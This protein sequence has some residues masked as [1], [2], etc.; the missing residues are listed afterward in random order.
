VYIHLSE[1][2]LE[3]AVLR[4]HGL[5]PEEKE[6]KLTL[7][8]C[9]RCGEG[10]TIGVKGC[11]KCGFIIDEQLARKTVQEEQD[12]FGSLSKRIERQEEVQGKILEVLGSIA[13]DVEGMKVAED[14][15]ITA[16]T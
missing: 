9:P 13:K 3:N 7:K 16:S 5:Q 12:V 11:V 8:K 4:E 1:S 15:I 2:D 14:D 10:N 6:E